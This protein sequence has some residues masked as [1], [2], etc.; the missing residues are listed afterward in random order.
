MASLNF[1]SVLHRRRRRLFS[2]PAVLALIVALAAIACLSWR[3][4]Q[5]EEAHAQVRAEISIERG[6]RNA[7]EP[8]TPRVNFD[9][10]EIA[11]INA[12]VRQLNLPWLQIFDAVESA[13]PEDVALLSL[14]PDAASDTLTIVG[15][16]RTTDTMLDY[17]TRLKSKPLF[18]DVLIKQHEIND[19]DPY[20]PVRFELTAH[21]K[22]RP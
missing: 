13:T 3:L 17:V 1:A 8:S 20:K 11:A 7:P 19:K 18:G 21:W 10:A 22:L 16:G 4:L 9:R 6:Q 14:A 15:E 2:A 12:A 5:I